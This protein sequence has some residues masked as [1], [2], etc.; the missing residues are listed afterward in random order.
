MVE[1]LWARCSEVKRS[2]ECTGAQRSSRRQWRFAAGKKNAISTKTHRLNRGVDALRKLR[3]RCG[4]AEGGK[5]IEARE[6]ATATL[7]VAIAD[8]VALG[9]HVF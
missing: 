3:W 6:M 1:K 7:S 4:L 2:S 5:D 8:D 9:F